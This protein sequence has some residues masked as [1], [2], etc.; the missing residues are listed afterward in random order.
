MVQATPASVSVAQCDSFTL[1]GTAIGGCRPYTYQW[2]NGS[3]ALTDGNGI[4]GATTLKLTVNNAQPANAGNY[5]LRVT[6]AASATVDSALIPVTVVAESAPTLVSA[7]GQTDLHT[8]VVTF[9]KPVNISS[10]TGGN[11]HVLTHRRR[12]EPDRHQLRCQ[13]RH[14]HA[15]DCRASRG[16]ATTTW[17]SALA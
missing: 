13:R 17:L 3:T 1:L 11:F 6:D 8:L 14:R 9:N 2:Y 16:P 5:R 12:A 15:P 4:S 7:V 10:A